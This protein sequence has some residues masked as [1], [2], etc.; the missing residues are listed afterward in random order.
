MSVDDSRVPRM[1]HV[2]VGDE[3]RV[4]LLA[5]LDDPAAVGD[6]RR[7]YTAWL[8]I[9]TEV[10]RRGSAIAVWEDRHPLTLDGVC[11]AEGAL[12]PMDSPVPGIMVEAAAA[13]SDGRHVIA[14]AAT[15]AIAEL[16]AQK[17]VPVLSHRSLP[18]EKAKN[19]KK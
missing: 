19:E 3:Q 9:G 8:A 11:E 12:V 16:P 13:S 2:D 14:P 15:A 5:L 10:E 18:A 7:L 6:A 1:D 4:A 17:T